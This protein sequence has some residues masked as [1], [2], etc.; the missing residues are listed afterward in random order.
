M[1]AYVYTKWAEEE[2]QFLIAT[3]G[4]LLTRDQ[5]VRLHRN[6]A[7]VV[8]KRMRMKRA[9][10]FDG[11][12][13]AYLPPWTAEEEEWLRDNYHKYTMRTLVRRLQRSEVAIILRKKRLGIRRTDGFYTARSASEIFGWDPKRVADMVHEGYLRGRRAPYLSGKHHPWVFNEQD[14]E[15][16]VRGY[17]WLVRPEK[18]QEHYL[19]SVVR[20]EWA[21]NPWYSSREAAQVVGV[22]PET[23]LRRLRNG[24]IP[25]FQ[26]SP[27]KPFSFWWI[28]RKDLLACF[29]RHD[30][31]A[32]RSRT[33]RNQQLTRRQRSGLPT[34]IGSLWALVCQDCAVRYT[35]R[36]KPR[37]RVSVAME[38]AR[39]QH[40]CRVRMN[41][42]AEIRSSE[43]MEVA[44]A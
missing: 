39:Q 24:E 43:L 14:L 31:T 33:T 29:H 8:A 32:E 20:Q 10:M 27:D 44:P 4:S 41:G 22:H 16:F 21:D 26:R 19:R 37:D 3:Y 18:M 36:T 40:K 7:D 1:S 34:Q 5:A 12:R 6:V 28:R 11:I 23:L 38:I 17:P 9:G 30:T 35:V 2:A 13:R 42:H 15:R 25:A